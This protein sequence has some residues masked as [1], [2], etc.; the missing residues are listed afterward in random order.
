[1]TKI[2]I[3]DNLTIESGNR[4][5]T[6]IEYFEQ[7]EVANIVDPEV[8][9]LEFSL[10]GSIGGIN[11]YKLTEEE[12]LPD[13]STRINQEFILAPDIAYSLFLHWKEVDK[14]DAA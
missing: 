1:M 3:D 10:N 11:G 8:L 13:G 4:A 12:I 6:Y 14:S 2:L 9:L 7:P 5:N